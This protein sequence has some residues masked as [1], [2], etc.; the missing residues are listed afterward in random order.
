MRSSVHDEREMDNLMRLA[1]HKFIPGLECVG[2]GTVS[3]LFIIGLFF[4]DVKDFRF[5][6]R[7]DISVSICALRPVMFG[8][9]SEMK[10]GIADNEPSI[11]FIF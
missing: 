1:R 9:I 7:R 8:S 3:F 11:I 6:Y 4:R 2:A 5:T 10:Y